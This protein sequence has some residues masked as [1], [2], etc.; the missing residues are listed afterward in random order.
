MSTT[1]DDQNVQQ[2]GRNSEHDV[3]GIAVKKFDT[4]TIDRATF[5]KKR[6]FRCFTEVISRNT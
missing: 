5:N 4:R 3:S 6:V 2:D 1:R